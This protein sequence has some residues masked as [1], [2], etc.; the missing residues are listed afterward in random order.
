MSWVRDKRERPA[1]ST[2]RRPL[3]S[4]LCRLSSRCPL[5]ATRDP[6]RIQAINLARPPNP[7]STG[8]S[9][10]CVCVTLVGAR[11]LPL[12]GR[13][14]S[15]RPPLIPANQI[16]AADSNPALALQLDAQPISLGTCVARWPS[17]RELVSL[18][19]EQFRWRRQPN[20]PSLAK[21]SLSLAG[22]IADCRAAICRAD[23][24]QPIGQPLYQASHLSRFN[25]NEYADSSL[26]A[27]RHCCCHL[28]MAQFARLII[29][30]HQQSASSSSSSTWLAEKTCWRAFCC[31][32]ERERE[33]T[34]RQ[35]A[36]RPAT[37]SSVGKQPNWRRLEAAPKNAQASTCV[38]VLSHLLQRRRPQHW[39]KLGSKLN[40]AGAALR[41]QVCAGTRRISSSN[42]RRH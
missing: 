36:S 4:E 24:L 37:S 22:R 40:L 34:P 23:S 31:Q 41:W 32:R 19:S 2:L 28:M 26:S 6:K 33:R 30:R 17:K 11:A 18:R 9:S 38:F 29:S 13:Q 1:P 25:S 16:R 39:A 20:S 35:P 5:P 42:S 14:P 7:G 3:S 12:D 21:L 10:T 15:E 27:G 8:V